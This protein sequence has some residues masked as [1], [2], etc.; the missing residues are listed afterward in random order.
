MACLISAFV[1][2][3]SLFNLKIR[4]MSAN[5]EV[6]KV[7][8]REIWVGGNRTFLIEG[9]IIHVV[10]NGEQTTELAIFQDEIDLELA[11]LV[12]GKISYLIDL[13][14]SG[15]SSPEAR[16]IWSRACERENTYK[17][18]VF[19]LHPVAKVIASFVFGITRKK[20]MR[21]F[22]SEEEA[23]SWLLA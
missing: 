16:A 19:G 3:L 20:D 6:K 21:F 5:I 17:V 2:I 1:I 14:H 11:T 13:N 18:A 7:S 8:Q 9:N 15:K 23:R 12:E 10:V 4:P 22:S